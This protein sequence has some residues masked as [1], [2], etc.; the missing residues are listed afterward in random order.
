MQ[1][2][3]NQNEKR[4]EVINELIK[5]P[6]QVRTIL[7]KSLVCDCVIVTP[8][9]CA[10]SEVEEIV[11]SKVLFFD[12]FSL[13]SLPSNK[14]IIL[15]DC[16]FHA[17]VKIES[18]RDVRIIIRNCRFMSKLQINDLEAG[19]VEFYDSNSNVITAGPDLFLLSD[20]DLHYSINVN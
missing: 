9:Y 16:I 13:Q 10:K 8:C 5:S 15:E 12:I 7:K 11:F 2:S 3:L 17:A 4:R 1:S 19:M 14:L 20:D 18:I 6:K